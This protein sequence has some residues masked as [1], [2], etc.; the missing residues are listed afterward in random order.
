MEQVIPHPSKACFASGN[1]DT[2]LWSLAA[3]FGPPGVTGFAE[4][5]AAARASPAFTFGHAHAP[6]YPA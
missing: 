4:H 1:V 6:W 2:I 3:A 5:P